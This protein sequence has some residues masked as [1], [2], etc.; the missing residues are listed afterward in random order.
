MVYEHVLG[1]WSP[2]QA[3]AVLLDARTGA[4]IDIKGGKLMI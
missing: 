4:T 1:G 3:L 2:S